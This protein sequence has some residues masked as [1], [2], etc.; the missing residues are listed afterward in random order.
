MNPPPPQLDDQLAKVRVHLRRAAGEV[1][2][3][4]IQFVV[5]LVDPVEDPAHRVPRHDLGAIRPGLDVA[6][7]AR[8]V[9][10]LAEVQ[11]QR[12]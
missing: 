1:G 8:E 4:N 5:M 11:L 10:H 3:L 12:G 9:A 2:D 6:V 7:M